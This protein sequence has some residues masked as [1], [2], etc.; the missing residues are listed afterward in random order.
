MTTIGSVKI[1]ANLKQIREDRLLTQG[2]L[3]KAA[4]I[5][6][7]SIVRIENDRTEPR[8]RTIR[9]LAEALGVEHQRLTGKR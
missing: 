5:G 1:G 3:A 6:L 7:S 9:K 8:Y 4:G 2:E